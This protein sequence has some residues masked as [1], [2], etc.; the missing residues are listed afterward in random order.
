MKSVEANARETPQHVDHTLTQPS[1]LPKVYSRIYGGVKH[2][3]GMRLEF[4]MY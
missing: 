1:I 3:D 4:C 2:S